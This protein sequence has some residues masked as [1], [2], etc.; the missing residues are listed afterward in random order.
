[1]KNIDYKQLKEQK[2]ILSDVIL[3]SFLSEEEVKAIDYVLNFIDSI[4]EQNP[5]Q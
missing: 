1:M 4:L 2:E 5:E 3:N